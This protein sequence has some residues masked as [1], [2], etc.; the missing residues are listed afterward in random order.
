MRD[1][2]Y[3]LKIIELY[4]L[5]FLNK[6]SLDRAGKMRKIQNHWLLIILVIFICSVSCTKKSFVCW[7]EQKTEAIAFAFDD[8]LNQVTVRDIYEYST[9]NSKKEPLKSHMP[10]GTH[11]LQMDQNV[12]T[13]EVI[14]DTVFTKTRLPSGEFIESHTEIKTENDYLNQR[15]YHAVYPVIWKYVFDKKLLKLSFSLS[16]LP[17]PRSAIEQKFIY[18]K[19][20]DDLY[21]EKTKDL[22]TEELSLIFSSHKKPTTYIYP[23]CERENDYS[24]K[25]ILR[26]IYRHLSFP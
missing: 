8:T 16:P 25:R 9:L 11:R 26:S 17:K 12:I 5:E 3:R 7:N 10:G 23:H 13:L 2:I 20:T 18:D 6:I 19:A 15:R 22:T 1:F 4:K 21:P 14:Q 24:L